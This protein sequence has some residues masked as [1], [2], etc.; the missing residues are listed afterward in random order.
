M[1]NEI[2]DILDENNTVL[3]YCIILRLR[4]NSL[5]YIGFRLGSVKGDSWQAASDRVWIMLEA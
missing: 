3:C 1:N 4:S 2:M 5:V